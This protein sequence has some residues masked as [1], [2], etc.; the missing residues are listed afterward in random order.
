MESMRKKGLG[1]GLGALI[2]ETAPA[3]ARPAERTLEIEASRPNP[4][5]PRTHFD[6]AAIAEMAESIREQGIV[7][8]LL[9]RS[10]DDGYEL[11]A[12]ERRLRAARLAGLTSVPV[13]VREM[14]DREALEIA[15]VENLQRED[16]TPLEEAAA[17][18]RLV[19]EF[20]LTQDEVAKR[21][22]KSRPA[23]ANTIRLLDLP[24]PILDELRAGRLTAGHAR[25]LLAV[26]ETN[27]QI[28][29]ANE[30]VRL[31][32]TVRQLEARVAG[33]P[34]PRASSPRAVLPEVAD[35]ERQLMRTL[36]TK[37]KI[38]SSG[39]RGRIVIEFH[40]P[41]EFERILAHLRPS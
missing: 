5:Q 39:K 32:L 30:A 18:S 9:V 8:P 31:R 14:S 41:D 34:E 37:V 24:E 17:Y 16:L 40:S 12:G 26:R 35:V 3:A 25:A 4:F 20:A 1:R 29:L 11:I 15:L 27:R 6:D 10:R 36:G 22:G 21:V 33:G 13:V 19:D 7:Q 23:V 28:A 38:R 2:R